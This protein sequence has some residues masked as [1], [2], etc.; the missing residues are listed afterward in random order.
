VLGHVEV[1]KD[2]VSMSFSRRLCKGESSVEISQD[3]TKVVKEPHAS[4]GWSDAAGVT[5]EQHRSKRVL[6]VTNSPAQSGMVDTHTSRSSEKTAF[7]GD[8]KCAIKRNE[9]DS[10]HLPSFAL[11]PFGSAAHIPRDDWLSERGNNW[12]ACTS[13]ATL[14]A[15]IAG[16]TSLVLAFPRV[17]RSGEHPFIKLMGNGYCFLGADRPRQADQRDFQMRLREA[18]KPTPVRSDG[19]LIASLA[20]AARDDAGENGIGNR[21]QHPPAFTMTD[22][23]AIARPLPNVRTNSSRLRRG[24]IELLIVGEAAGRWRRHWPGRAA[25]GSR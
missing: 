2:A 24:R 18:D 25:G 11:T 6:K 1:D 23:D 12:A 16:C 7:L 3:A 9:L 15:S 20:R 17:E 19:D 4:W 13:Q 10:A 14:L 22:L 8:H 5:L 21:A